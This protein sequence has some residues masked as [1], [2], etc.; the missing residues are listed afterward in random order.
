MQEQ[1]GDSWRPVAYISRTLTETERKYAQLEKEALA[2]TWACE[3]FDF[4]LAGRVFQI[5]TDHSPLIKLLGTSDLAEMPLRIQRFKLRL[6]R[7]DYKIF[8]TP[9]KDMYLADCLSRPAEVER[10]I[11]ESAKRVEMHVNRILMADTGQRYGDGL[12]EE[13]TAKG[14]LDRD[15]REAIKQTSSGWNNSRKSYKGGMKLY[16]AHRHSLMVVGELLMFGESSD[17]GIF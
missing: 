8:H 2:V 15:Y 7:Y 6:M 11:V 16:Y 5:E 4:Y 12:L 9:G 10:Y 3:K 13:V 1:G 14:R 17:S